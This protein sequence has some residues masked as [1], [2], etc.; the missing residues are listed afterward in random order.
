MWTNVKKTD[1]RENEKI[2]ED[3]KVSETLKSEFR[4]RRQI[5]R[6]RG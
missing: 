5:I 2:V 6:G 3:T 4:R 1:L